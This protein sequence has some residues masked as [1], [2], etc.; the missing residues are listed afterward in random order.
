M[1]QKLLTTF[2]T[3]CQGPETKFSFLKKKKLGIDFIAH[4]PTNGE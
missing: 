4:L 1:V 2:K 3:I